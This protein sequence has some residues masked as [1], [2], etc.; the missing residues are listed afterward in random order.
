MARAFARSISFP[1]SPSTSP[2]ARAP[3]SPY[4]GRSVSLPCRSHPI[5]AYLHTHIRSVRAWAQQGPPGLAASVAARLA[6]VDA[7][8]TV[9]GDLLDLPEA[10]AALSGAGGSID[11]LLVS[12]LRLTDA[13]GCFQEAVVALKQDI[14]EALAAVNKKK[15]PAPGSGSEEIAVVAV[16]K[17]L[18]ELEECIEELEA[19][20]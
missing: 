4:H 5:F 13:H 19:G 18:E 20:S 16:A 10:Q 1:L 12:F 9:L 17:R 11:R 7:L 6:H 2:K 14:A 15:T 3:S 8:H